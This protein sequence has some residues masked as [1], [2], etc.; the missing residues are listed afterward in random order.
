MLHQQLA[1]TPQQW[2]AV[3][4]EDQP[5]WTKQSNYS[6]DSIQK[7]EWLTSISF[8]QKIGECGSDCDKING[9]SK[10]TIANFFHFK[11][12]SFYDWVSKKKKSFWNKLNEFSSLQV[13]L[14]WIIKL[15]VCYAWSFTSNP[16]LCWIREEEKRRRETIFHFDCQ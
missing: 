6:D 7:I 16:I 14:K 3:F 1:T 2:S 5:I 11:K 4:W 13:W 15:R 12:T 8:Y 9:W 10:K